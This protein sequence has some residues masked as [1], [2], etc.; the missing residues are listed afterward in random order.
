MKGTVH[1]DARRLFSTAHAVAVL[2]NVENLLASEVVNN[3]STI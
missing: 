1:R 2:A 3:N